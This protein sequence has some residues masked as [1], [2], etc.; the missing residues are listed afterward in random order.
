MVL[1]GSYK[2]KSIVKEH[3]RQEGQRAYG[4]ASVMYD[5]LNRIGVDSVLSNARAY[6]EVDLAVGH[7]EHT[8]DDDLI[9]CDRNYPS[10]RFVA[11]LHKR[12]RNY[13]IRC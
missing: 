4:L 7:L 12:N 13:V 5:V 1:T 3:Y 10:Y 11:T 2:I 8:R 6:Y 9:I